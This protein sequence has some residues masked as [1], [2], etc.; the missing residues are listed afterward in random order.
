VLEHHRERLEAASAISPEVVS[1]R[2]YYSVE[3]RDELKGFRFPRDV[4]RHLPG[5]VIPVYAVRP[6]EPGEPLEPT[7]LLLR[8]DVLYQ[9]K[10]GRT[11]KYLSPSAQENMLDV[12]PLAREWLLDAEVPLVVTEGVTP[13]TSS[14]CS[15]SSRTS[16]SAQR[17][18]APARRTFLIS[19][20]GRV[21]AGVG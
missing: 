20:A 13:R 10:D 8:P 1:A 14:L 16:R 11:A 4:G 6:R 2:G 7:G 9:F 12:H 18:C 5:L 15:R 21:R 3:T 19:C 17:R